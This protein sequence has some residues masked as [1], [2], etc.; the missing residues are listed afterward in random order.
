MRIYTITSKERIG[1]FINDLVGDLTRWNGDKPLTVTM[2]GKKEKRSLDQNALY[3]KWMQIIADETGNDKDDVHE[4]M[5]GFFLG[6]R[7]MDINGV[8]QLIPVSS[9]KQSVRD[10][11]EYMEKIQAWAATHL[12]ITL[13]VPDDLIDYSQYER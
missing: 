1:Q 3:W 7:N 5:K 12:N 4:Y 10:M 8:P 6:M 2:Q 11:A 13:P 9:K